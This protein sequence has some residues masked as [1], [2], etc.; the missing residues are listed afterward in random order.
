MLVDIFGK[1]LDTFKESVWDSELIKGVHELLEWNFVVFY[2]LGPSL[3]WSIIKRDLVCA[4][5]VID[6]GWFVRY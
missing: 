5:N 3:F 4:R 2:D 6:D 1:E